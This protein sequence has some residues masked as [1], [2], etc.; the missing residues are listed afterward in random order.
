MTGALVLLSGGMDS[1]TLLSEVMEWRGTKRATV[2]TI[3]FDYGQRHVKEL[4]AA[5][6]VAKHYKVRFDV[7]DVTGINPHLA[8][9][10]TDHTQPLPEGHYADESM[11]ATVVPGRN[12]IMLSVAAGIAASRGVSHV[13]T[14]V[15]AGDHPIYPD[16]RPDFIAAIGR[17]L[18]LATGV[19]VVA[20]FV[21]RT[22]TEIAALG[23][24]MNAPLELTWSCYAGGDVHCG[25]CGTCVERIEAFRDADVT[26]PT[27]YEVNA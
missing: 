9:A 19:E 17:A 10:L 24:Y 18:R 11:K 4:D 5:A 3:A 14:A 6:A 8:S 20:P 12:A 27:T 22:K 2:H 26:D 1:T 21:D 23:W 7:V 16:C 25:R 13:A 15:H